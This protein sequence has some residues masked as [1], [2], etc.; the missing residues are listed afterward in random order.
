[1]R[2][3][4]RNRPS[5][6]RDRGGRDRREDRQMYRATCADCGKSCEVPF[7]PSGSKP[8]YCDDCFKRNNDSMGGRDRDNRGR[9]RGR[10][11][12]RQMY[13]AICDSCGKE[14]ELP[15]KPSSGKPVYCD[16]CFRK[17]SPSKYGQSN[18]KNDEIIAK[19]D[20]IIQL[21]EGKKPAKKTKV[22]KLKKTVSKKVVKKSAPKKTTPK[23]VAKKGAS[24]IK[25]VVK[26]PAKGWSA[27]GRKKSK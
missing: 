27:S 20:K 5:G 26:K 22:V 7:K 21:L 14:C 15:F 13:K 1:M 4:N 16:D 8:V 23:K 9:N 3:F 18:E 2:N 24:K 10:R 6:G 11:E 25:K 17:K 19:L 12:D